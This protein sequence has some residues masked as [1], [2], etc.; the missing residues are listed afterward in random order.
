MK[1]EKKLQLETFSVIILVT[2]I[3]TVGIMIFNTLTTR[4]K[5]ENFEKESELVI[6]AAKNA[7]IAFSKEELPN[8]LATSTDGTTKAMCITLKGLEKNNLITQDLSKWDGYVVIEMGEKTTYKIWLTDKN[9]IIKGIEESD[10]KHLKINKTL[11]KYDK[12]EL[13]DDVKNSF[14]STKRYESKC[15][16]EKIE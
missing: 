11:E 4:R 12:E 14:S 1:K 3:L 5:V 6:G 7:Y 2:L 8:Y 10:I 16:N 13:S 9:Y 15:I